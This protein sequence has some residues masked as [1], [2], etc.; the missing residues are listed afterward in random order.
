MKS[1]IGQ[2]LLAVALGFAV[3]AIIVVIAQYIVWH[4]R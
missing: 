3:A 4:V 2:W 1:R